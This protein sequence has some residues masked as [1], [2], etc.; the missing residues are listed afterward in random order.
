MEEM[1]SLII[2]SI[3]GYEVLKSERVNMYRTMFT[4]KKVASQIKGKI[5]PVLDGQGEVSINIGIGTAKSMFCKM[6]I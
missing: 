2:F 4:K 6:I 3:C 1:G 5:S